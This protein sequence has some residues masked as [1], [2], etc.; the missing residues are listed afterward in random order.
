M[1]LI[2]RELLVARIDKCIDINGLGSEPLMAIR[3]IKALISV[4]PTVDAIP[5]EWLQEKIRSEYEPDSKA[6]LRVLRMWEK[7]KECV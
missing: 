4:L 1:P 2:N 6:A 3:D 5:M 7:A